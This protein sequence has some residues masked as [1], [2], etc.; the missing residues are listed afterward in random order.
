VDPVNEWGQPS[1]DNDLTIFSFTIMDDPRIISL[2]YSQNFDG[3]TAPAMPAAWTGYVNS[4]S[5]YATA[6]TYSSTTYAQSPPNSVKMYNSSDMT[7]DLRIVTPQIT[8][9]MNSIKLSFYARVSSTP[10]TVLVGTVNTPEGTFTQLDSFELTTTKT[11]YVMSLADYAGTD[12]YICFKHAVT[13]SSKT[14]YIDDVYMEEL[15]DTDMSVVSLTG[16]SYGFQNTPIAHTVTV[17]NNGTEPVSNYTVYLKSVTT[18]AILGQE[19]FTDPLAADATNAV[20]FTWNPTSLGAMDIYGEVYVADDAEAGNNTTDPMAFNVYQEG[21]LFEGFEGGVIPANW[22]VL[23]ADGG[24]QVWQAQT[25]NPYSGTY[26][27]RVRYETSSLDNDDWLITPPLQVTS[28]TTDNIS[29]WMRTYSGTSADAWQVLIST[30]DTNPASFTMIDEG[31]GML[32]NYVQKSY[33]LDSYG[34]A[35][36]YLA[37]RYMGAFDWYLYVDE[38]VGPPVYEP[39]SLDTPEVTISTVG[40]NVVLNWDAIPYATSYE[41]MAADAPEGPYTLAATVTAP[42]YSTA[43]LTKKFFK[44]IA[45]AGATRSIVSPV[46]SLEQQ[47]LQDEMDRAA[48]SRQ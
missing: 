9:P 15:V 21:I 44:V 25:I 40:S 10:E 29:F 27:A 6:E 33:N 4:T 38:F 12:Q 48:R 7:A 28:G 39:A 16:M 34:D 35:I 20:E 2:P 11:Q 32:A 43:S 30:T 22:T 36:I 31:D 37:V 47:L 14:I 8:V 17:K 24:T 13:S 1:D 19:S 3:V 42:T 46:L 26:A 18:R 5:T 41:V 23:N 45:K